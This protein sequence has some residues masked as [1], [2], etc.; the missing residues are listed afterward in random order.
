MLVPVLPAL[1]VSVLGV[2]VLE[3]VVVA[4]GPVL[5]VAAQVPAVPVLAD[6]FVPEVA[7]PAAVVSQSVAARAL[8]PIAAEALSL[9]AV[10][11]LL[12]FALLQPPFGR[13]AQQLGSD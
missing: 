4:V 3:S 7:V 5:A 11:E 9:V 12:P 6:L 2:E 1:V 13:P 8:V 10:S